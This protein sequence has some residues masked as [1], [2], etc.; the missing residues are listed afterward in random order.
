MNLAL[1]LEWEKENHDMM[2]VRGWK[3]GRDWNS[4]NS[5][6]DRR[7][8]F[9]LMFRSSCRQLHGRCHRHY[10]TDRSRQRIIFSGI[11]PTGIPHLGNYL[12]ALKNWVTLQNSLP[13]NV[14][15]IYSIVDLHA[16]TVPYDPEKLR[17]E[18]D[19][20]WAVLYAVGLDMRRCTI[21]EQSAVSP[22][23]R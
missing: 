14:S 12:G 7:L 9:L 4:W 1:A 21:F 8:L 5:Y 15:I 20:M 19:D 2:M 18:R 3:D 11:Q 17:Q 16:I 10:S 13:S 23:C 22:P 6:V